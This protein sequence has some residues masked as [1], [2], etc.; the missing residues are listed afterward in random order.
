ML[1]HG[2]AVKIIRKFAKQQPKIGFASTCDMLLPVDG[3]E[4][5]AY[6]ATFDCIRNGVY[7]PAWWCDPMLA[8]KAPKGCDWLTESDLNEIY[9]PLDYCAYNIYRADIAEGYDYT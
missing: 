8:G 1:A 4:E 5:K 3:D 9:E 2:K 6:R 7:N